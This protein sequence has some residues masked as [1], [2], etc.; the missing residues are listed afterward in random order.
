MHTH[1]DQLI[2][3]ICVDDIDYGLINNEL[4]EKFIKLIDNEFEM[5]SMRELTFFLEFLKKFEFENIYAKNIVMSTNAS[6][7]KDKNRMAIDVK[8]YRG[9][10]GL[11]LYITAN[12]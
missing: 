5:S 3:Q 8:L 7:D 9:L 6:L 12:T 4:C 2:C 1:K 11:L 10:I